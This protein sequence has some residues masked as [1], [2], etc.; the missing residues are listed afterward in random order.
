MSRLVGCTLNSY[1]GAGGAAGNSTHIYTP[2]SLDAKGVG[3]L[4]SSVTGN[5][6][7]TRFTAEVSL[8]G[9]GVNPLTGRAKSQIRI[10]APIYRA[11]LL[12]ETATCCTK[13]AGM[14]IGVAHA[15]L[16]IDFPVGITATEQESFVAALQTT[17]F[18]NTNGQMGLLMPTNLMYDTAAK[19]ERLF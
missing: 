5:D 18:Q 11:P 13:P 6:G 12:A 8:Y 10:H 4:R 7:Q 2:V 17:L 1:P 3:L 16:S 9:N 15:D 14:I 19:G